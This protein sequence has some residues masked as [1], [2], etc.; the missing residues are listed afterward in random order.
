[1]TT[2][3]TQSIM[4]LRFVINYLQLH[5]KLILLS[6]KKSRKILLSV[7]HKQHKSLHRNQDINFDLEIHYHDRLQFYVKSDQFYSFLQPLFPIFLNSC[8]EI[9]G[10][11]EKIILKI[12]PFIVLHFCFT[13]S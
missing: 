12:R 2:F 10:N 7:A 4:V 13:I 9:Y 8:D 6:K 3:I 11:V 5:T 1:M